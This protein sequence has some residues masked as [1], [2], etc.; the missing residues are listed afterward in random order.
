V[1]LKNLPKKLFRAEKTNFGFWQRFCDPLVIR[2][3]EKKSNSMREKGEEG[4]A[5]EKHIR[6]ERA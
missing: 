3:G 6:L 5:S 4:V 2:I 1:K